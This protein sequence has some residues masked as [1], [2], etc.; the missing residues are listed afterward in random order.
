MQQ[1]FAANAGDVYLPATVG[2]A[3][4]DAKPADFAFSVVQDTRTGDII[5]KLVNAGAA[6]RPLHLALPGAP[7]FAASATKTVLTGEPLAVNAVGAPPA[8]APATSPITVG[9]SFDY[10]AP[11]HSLTVIRLHPR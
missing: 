10:E 8:V 2:G 4:A 9:R 1:L 6:V 7:E 11:A 5:L 3:A